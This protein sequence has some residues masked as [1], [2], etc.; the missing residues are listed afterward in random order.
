MR[1]I[2]KEGQ[3]P[4]IDERFI[5]YENLTPIFYGITS[6]E[7]EKNIFDNLNTNFKKFYDLKYGPMYVAGAAKNEKSEFEFTSTP[8]LGFLDVFIRVRDLPE[9]NAKWDE[10]NYNN[11]SKV[12][13]LLLDHAYD[14]P[15]ACFTEGMGI[16]GYLSGCSGRSWDNGNFFHTLIVGICGLE[17]S[18]YGISITAPKQLKGSPVSELDNMYWRNAVY[19]FEWKG[20]GGKIK[21]V[22]VDDKV[23]KPEADGNY[24]LKDSEGEH[25]VIVFTASKNR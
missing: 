22:T 5:P 6:K 24:L 3:K 4:H 2:N 25:E 11:A 12:F 18:Q 16:Y 20:K 8:W 19:K 23:I 9:Y 17:K 1:I 14:I 21:K 15:P 10:K 7:Q 13:K